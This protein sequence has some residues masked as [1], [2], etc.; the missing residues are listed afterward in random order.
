L[1]PHRSYRETNRNGSD[2]TLKS[3]DNSKHSIN[4][5]HPGIGQ[6][7]CEDEPS[8]PSEQDIKKLFFPHDESS[9]TLQPPER[10][11]H[12]SNY[13]STV[14]QVN[15][16]TDEAIELARSETTSETGSGYSDHLDRAIIPPNIGY[17]EFGRPY[18]PEFDIQVLSGFVRRM[19]TIESA[20]SRE[21]SSMMSSDRY[22]SDRDTLGTGY[23]AGSSR[24]A[25]RNTL[26]SVD[27]NQGSHPHSG[28]NSIAL[29][30]ANE[31][32]EVIDPHSPTSRPL[33]PAH[34]H[35]GVS[36]PSSGSYYTAASRRTAATTPLSFTSEP[37]EIEHV[38]APPGLGVDELGRH[39]RR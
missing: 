11:D 14:S 32:G 19:P 24:P 27:F 31:F 10:H 4:Y 38:G 33:T 28:R 2:S 18:P 5:P 9:I 37:E 7:Y 34:Q 36:Y 22:S 16:E 21:A 30:I 35:T 29:V 12:D 23:S 39:T 8:G 26:L 3:H 1:G 15:R 6:L 25:T 17:D 20:G 13:H